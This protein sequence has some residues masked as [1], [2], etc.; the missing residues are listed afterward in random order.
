MFSDILDHGCFNDF[1]LLSTAEQVSTLKF[2][3]QCYN[4]LP[5]ITFLPTDCQGI[6][7]LSSRG[8]ARRRKFVVKA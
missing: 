5:S 8:S 2:L 3:R 1:C 6:H 4:Y 7:T